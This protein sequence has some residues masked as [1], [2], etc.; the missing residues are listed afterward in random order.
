VG[1]RF[2]FLLAAVV[3]LA[4]TGLGRAGGARGAHCHS[5][6]GVPV[7]VSDSGGICQASSDPTSVANA[8][9]VGGGIAQ[10][11]ASNGSTSAAT[12]DGSGIA[13]ASADNGSDAHSTVHGSGIAQSHADNGSSAAAYTFGSGLSQA[14]ADNGGYAL[15][16][17]RGEALAQASAD[18]PDSRAVA[19]A[20]GNGVAQSSANAGQRVKHVNGGS[21]PP[22]EGEQAV[23]QPADLSTSQQITA[24]ATVGRLAVI[25]ISSTNNGTTTAGDAY[26]KDFL[27]DGYVFVDCRSTIDGISGGFCWW[28]GVN[29][30]V[31]DLGDF[32][33]GSSTTV[34]IYVRPT[35]AGN[36]VNSV[37]IG[38]S[39]GDFDPDSTNNFFNLP[40]TTAAA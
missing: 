36:S 6:G 34:M 5:T 30:V 14:S 37:G 19:S 1:T 28:D 39:G 11:N 15:A 12:V 31:D 13:Q 18:G 22:G 20:N 32:A 17:A 9:A 25:T 2:L 29:M 33:P 10:S 3:A 4:A 16:C 35:V 26:V 8:D 40:V 38:S 24:G 27:P 23:P 7:A 21:C